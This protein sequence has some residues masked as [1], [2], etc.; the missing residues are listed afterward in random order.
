MERPLVIG[1]YAIY[2]KIASG[3]MG[4]V[5]LGRCRGLNGFARTVAI[6]RLH[7]HH[8]ENPDFVSMFLDEARLAAR[9]VTDTSFGYNPAPYVDLALVDPSF[10]LGGVL[11][12]A[13]LPDHDAYAN[14]LVVQS[15][16]EVALG[17]NV[18]TF[19]QEFEIYL[20]RFYAT[21]PDASGP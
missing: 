10:G 3:G 21:R 14:G 17:G 1:R 6:K 18:D 20:A 12:Y 13:P 19:E 8:T 11:A 7:P 4:T 15:T 5:H 16:G 9:V 2:G